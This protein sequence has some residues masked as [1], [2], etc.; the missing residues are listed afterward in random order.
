MEREEEKE[1]NWNLNGI[2][3]CFY[4]GRLKFDCCFCDG[5]VKWRF[6]SGF[7]CCNFVNSL[8]QKRSRNFRLILGFNRMETSYNL[9]LKF[10]LSFIKAAQKLTKN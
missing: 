3:W 6:Y 2:S 5:D 8:G 10:V 7:I 4:Y 9:F 1:K